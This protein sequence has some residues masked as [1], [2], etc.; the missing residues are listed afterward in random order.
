MIDLNQAQRGVVIRVG[1]GS[2]TATLPN[3]RSQAEV[4]KAIP[5][6]VD[7]GLLTVTPE[8]SPMIRLTQDGWDVY[9]RIRPEHMERGFQP[10]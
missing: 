5:Q 10:K 9:R 7:L 4:L 8:T 1:N 3:V 2:L 6:L